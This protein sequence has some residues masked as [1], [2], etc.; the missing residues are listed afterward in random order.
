MG[1]KPSVVTYNALVAVVG[2]AGMWELGLTLYEE[3]GTNG[4]QPD[5]V[6]FNSL[7]TSCGKAWKV[8]GRTL[9]LH[10]CIDTKLDQCGRNAVYY[11][12]MQCSQRFACIYKIPQ[13]LPTKACI[14]HSRVSRITCIQRYG[15][16]TCLPD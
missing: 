9:S 11:I 8:R 16:H 4:V 2:K 14:I 3:M 12:V 10:L 6:T 5:V 13:H 15:L 1:I 7:I